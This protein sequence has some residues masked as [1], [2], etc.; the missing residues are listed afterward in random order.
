MHFSH[1]TLQ[2]ANW[3]RKVKCLLAAE[4]LGSTVLIFAILALV[5]AFEPSA[6]AQTSP[7][8]S[9]PLITQSINEGNLVVLAGNTRP[10]A[11]D[12]ANDRGI[13]PDSMPMPH[14]MLQLQRPAA[15]EKA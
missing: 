13:V 10:E 2:R 4:K 1:R 3:S 14:M 9:Q 15:Q 12:P 5:F 7:G 6:Y 11:R 8:P